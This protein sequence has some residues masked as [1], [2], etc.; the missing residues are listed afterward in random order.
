ARDIRDDVRNTAITRLMASGVAEES[1]LLRLERFMN[2]DRGDVVRTF[3]E[4]L[5]K[6]LHLES[7]ANC[8]S[9]ITALTSEL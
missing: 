8:L 5:P 1:I 2:P 9:P 6:G 4:P 3:G 7:T